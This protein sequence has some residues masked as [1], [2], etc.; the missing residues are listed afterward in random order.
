[1]GHF[2]QNLGNNSATQPSFDFS[3][4][5]GWSDG[6]QAFCVPGV[7]DTGQE[8]ASHQLDV[9]PSYEPMRL[10]QAITVP[11]PQA[12]LPPTAPPVE[13]NPDNGTIT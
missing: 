11:G 3:A 8:A 6:G 4:C 10:D 13:T 1:M 5:G 9:R 12:S 7:Q 2:G